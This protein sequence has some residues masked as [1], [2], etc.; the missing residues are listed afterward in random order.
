MEIILLYNMDTAKTKALSGQSKDLIEKSLSFGST[1][2]EFEHTRKRRAPRRKSDC[3]HEGF[4]QPRPSKIPTNQR[5]T[6]FVAERLLKL[7]DEYIFLDSDF[8]NKNNIFKLLNEISSSLLEKKIIFLDVK[9]Q[10][11]IDSKS[12][13]LE[14]ISAKIQILLS[15]LFDFKIPEF[16]DDFISKL[17]GAA[18]FSQSEI[19]EQKIVYEQI[20][21]LLVKYH[22]EIKSCSALLEKNLLEFKTS[23]ESLGSRIQADDSII[24]FLY[25]VR[26]AGLDNS[27]IRILKNINRFGGNQAPGFLKSLSGPIA[28]E[29][30]IG[31][32]SGY[33][34]RLALIDTLITSF[35]YD[36]PKTLSEKPGSLFL[37][38]GII[39]NVIELLNSIA[40]EPDRLAGANEILK[41]SL[42]KNLVFL[43]D[44]CHIG[45]VKLFLENDC[46][47]NKLIGQY[48]VQTLT[49][50][51]C[52]TL[53]FKFYSKLIEFI[54]TKFPGNAE[55][56]IDSIE[57][58][59]LFG[60]QDDVHEK[61]SAA[62]ILGYYQIVDFSIGSCL[63]EID[64][65]SHFVALSPSAAKVNDSRTV[66]RNE[67]MK[68]MISTI[69]SEL[70]KSMD[71]LLILNMIMDGKSD[72]S[73]YDC[74]LG[75]AEHLAALETRLI[76][77]IS[78][79]LKLGDRHYLA[80]SDDVINSDSALNEFFELNID[81]LVP[82]STV[83]DALEL[84]GISARH[85]TR[86]V[87]ELSLESGAKDFGHG[88]S[89][90]RGDSTASAAASP[91]S[92]DRHISGDEDRIRAMINTG[93]SKVVITKD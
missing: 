76:N 4:E 81:L 48:T 64:G 14:A 41:F 85:R 54:R 20:K 66:I 12:G 17:I 5:K 23:I 43:Y 30:G 40:A 24:D 63:L 59:F 2:E 92:A 80:I 55:S 33:E 9:S 91:R 71:E 67:I 10:E 28:Y 51:S 27:S 77:N 35:L 18:N 3:R 44:V 53:G 7:F 39:K 29:I 49:S 16:S 15:E 79:L 46:F 87:E 1:V 47:V 88:A 89:V 62:A 34:D 45:N 22:R 25:C 73:E 58:E 65:P 13:E 74:R 52:E 26:L 56:I 83:S 82:K 90:D 19:R 32:P 72:L 8:R 61:N 69:A 37:Y 11:D 38:D 86:L 93:S 36:Y 70:K 60:F 42:I 50:D 6:E 84:H 57:S 31:R 75:D 21:N 78:K 68:T